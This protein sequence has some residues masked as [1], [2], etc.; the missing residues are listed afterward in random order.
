MAPNVPSHDAG[1][2]PSNR[3]QEDGP[4]LPAGRSIRAATKPK[5]S[6]PRGEV[7]VKLFRPG[8]RDDVRSN[9]LISRRL[10]SFWGPLFADGTLLP[11]KLAPLGTR[12]MPFIIRAPSMKA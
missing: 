11:L 4:M 10:P 8:T 6:P 12:V 1:Q 7:K 2:G 9:V 5:Q 3:C